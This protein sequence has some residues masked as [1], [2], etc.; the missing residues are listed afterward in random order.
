MSDEYPKM[1]PVITGWSTTKDGTC[2][3]KYRCGNRIG[4]VAIED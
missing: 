2:N 1:C 4:C 3:R